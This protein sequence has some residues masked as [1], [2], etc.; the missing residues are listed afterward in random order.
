MSYI[1]VRYFSLLER[2]MDNVCCVLNHVN[3]KRFADVFTP[4]TDECVLIWNQGV[5]SCNYL[6]KDN[7]ITDQSGP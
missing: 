3:P 5:C 6:S 2:N 4:G 1:Y 7:I